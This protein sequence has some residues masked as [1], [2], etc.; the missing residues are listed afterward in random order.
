MSTV[1]LR[2]T[3]YLF[4][5]LANFRRYFEETTEKWAGVKAKINYEA[6]AKAKG[7]EKAYFY[8]CINDIRNQGESQADYDARLKQQE[9]EFASINSI[10]NTHVRLGSMTGTYKNRR[11][12]GV[13]ISLAVDALKHAERRNMEIALLVTGDGDFKPLIQALVEMG[14]FAWVMAD[15]KHTS[16][17]LKLAAD[18]YIPL[19][20]IEYYK[21]AL[22]D[23]QTRYS[24]P[25]VF[26]GAKHMKN[27]GYYKVADGTVGAVRAERYLN[28]EI[29]G[30]AIYYQP[31]NPLNIF[32]R[33]PDKIQ[34]FCE[35]NYGPVIF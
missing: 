18:R 24:L 34:V 1:R 23:F 15:K 28:G 26:H 8:D 10:E 4:V 30:I 17:E 22:P 19:G 27:H 3:N 5:D 31:D 25:D 33:L 16:E 14:L 32:G 13:D 35:L 2:R 9:E 11:Q 29:G 7:A 6:L 12:K 21:Y 20:L